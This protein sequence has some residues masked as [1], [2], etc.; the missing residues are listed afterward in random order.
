VHEATASRRL[1]RLHK[2]LRA[3][4]EAILTNDCGWSQTEA[5]SAMTYASAN[6]EIDLESLLRNKTASGK[7]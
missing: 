6:P 1:T 4:L 3:R 7:E 2:E 5:S